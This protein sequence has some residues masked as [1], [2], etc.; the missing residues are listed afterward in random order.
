MT[1]VL[2][3]ATI[4]I[5]PTLVLTGV[6]LM[7]KL[8]PYHSLYVYLYQSIAYTTRA[9]DDTHQSSKYHRHYRI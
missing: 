4:E 1:V 7:I 6:L 3:T 2:E 5:I 8:F 9:A